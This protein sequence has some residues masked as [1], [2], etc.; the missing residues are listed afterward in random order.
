[1]PNSIKYSASAQTLALKKGNLWIGTGDVGKGP[2]SSTAYYNGVTPAAGGYTI[3]S[4]SATQTG[5]L[6]YFSAANDAALIAETNRIAGT[7]Y[8]TAAQCLAYFATQTDR[9]ACNIDYPAVITNGLVLNLD[10]GF[11]PS[12]P[13]T[14]TTWYDVSSSSNN[15]ALTNGPTF[16][17]ANNGSIV[18]DGVDDYI[19][20]SQIFSGNMDSTDLTYNVWC[21]PTG[22]SSGFGALVNQGQYNYEPAWM[23]NGS[24]FYLWY[25]DSTIIEANGLSQNKWYYVNVIKNGTTHTMTIYYDNTVFS[26]TV[27]SSKSGI[28]WGDRGGNV[29]IYIGQNG[30]GEDY[31]G[32]IANVRVYNRALSAAEVLQNYNVT[33]GRF[34]L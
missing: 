9:M 15:G 4:Y 27:T 26:Q 24:S 14:G 21:Y 6:S 2:S 1:M 3:Y 8:T 30:V 12:Y 11:T 34:G 32:R 22:S 31:N 13:T 28:N 16:N 5:N 18:F 20:A 7:S 33:K 17:S 25:W 23:N 10:A 19:T 29:N